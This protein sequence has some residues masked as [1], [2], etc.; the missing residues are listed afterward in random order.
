MAGPMAKCS[1]C[2]TPV[3]RLSLF[4]GPRDVPIST[5]TTR[6]Q[7]SRD[8]QMITVTRLNGPAFALNPDLIERVEATPD[9]VIHLVGGTNYVV[10]ETVDEIITRVR[11]SRAAVIALSHLI[12]QRTDDGPNLRVVPRDEPK[13]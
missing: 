4:T 12:D 2:V 7:R 3:E 11:E 6:E 1:R 5:G 10:V 9:T 13:D 8:G